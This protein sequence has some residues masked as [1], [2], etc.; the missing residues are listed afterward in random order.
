MSRPKPE[1]PLMPA[2]R[3]INAVGWAGVALLLGFTLYYYPMLPEIIPHHFDAAGQPDSFGDKKIILVLPAIGVLLFIFMQYLSRHPH[4]FNYNVPIT[5][6]NAQEQYR[7][8]SR[9]IRSLAAFISCSFAY[10]TY[11]TVQAARERWDGLGT[12]FLP[13]FLVLIFGLIGYFLWRSQRAA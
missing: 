7:I 5:E 13:V 1:I 12:W 3:A 8:A 2:D 10:I 9:M 6:Q 4:T 11:G